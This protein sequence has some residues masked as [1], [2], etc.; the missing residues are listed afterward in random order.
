MNRWQQSMQHIW[1]RWP[2]SL[3][4]TWARLQIICT[5][6]KI[7]CYVTGNEHVVLS[8]GTG[9]RKVH[10]LACAGRQYIVSMNLKKSRCIGAWGFGLASLA[11]GDVLPPQGSMHDV[12]ACNAMNVSNLQ[13]S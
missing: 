8:H 7:Y 5:N 10:R 4:R 6:C 12:H 2:V 11:Y 1:K 13:V 9:C 3:I